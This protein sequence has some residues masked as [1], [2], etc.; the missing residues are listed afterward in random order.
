M[1]KGSALDKIINDSRLMKAPNVLMLLVSA[2]PYATLT[3]NSIIPEVFVEGP[4][5]SESI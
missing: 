5:L 3:K 1:K 4:G 2:T